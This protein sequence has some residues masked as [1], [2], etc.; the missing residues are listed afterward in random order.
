VQAGVD[1]D[2][3]GN[4]SGDRPR[5]LPPRVGRG[6]VDE[7]LRIINEYRASVRQAPITKELLKLDMFRSFDLRSTK[8]FSLSGARR[9]E[10]FLE[11]FNVF[12]TVNFTGGNSNMRLATFLIRTGARDPRQIQWGARYSF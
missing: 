3:D 5:G 10:V 7:E 6:D 12:N 4:T 2:G 9:I 8:S 1:L 11:A